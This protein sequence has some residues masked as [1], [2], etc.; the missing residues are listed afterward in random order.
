MKDFLL[1]FIEKAGQK[2]E[3]EL[4]LSTYQK[5]PMMTFAVIHVSYEVL[6]FR[7]EALAESIAMMNR[8]DIYPLV[9][10]RLQPHDYYPSSTS[11]ANAN[12]AFDDATIKRLFTVHSK[13][14]VKEI[15]KRKGRVGVSKEG[16]AYWPDTIAPRLKINTNHILSVVSQHKTVIVNPLTVKN[17]KSIVLD[18]ERLCK[19]LVKTIRSKKYILINE[20]GGILDDTGSV[21]SFLN[22]S[23]PKDWGNVRKDMKRKVR[24]IRE[25]V[26]QIPHCAV[27]VTSAEDLL[28]EI[29]TIKGKGTF[30]KY[31]VLKS[32]QSPEDINQKK[33]RLLIENAFQKKLIDPYFKQK[34]K[35]IIYQK[36]Y[37]GVAI[38]Q[39][40]TGIPYLDKFA[41]G[42]LF[43]G[44]GLGTTLWQKVCRKYPK[45]VWRAHPKNP[46]NRFYLRECDGCIKDDAWHVYWRQLNWQEIRKVVPLV[47]QRK[48]SLFL[49]EDTLASNV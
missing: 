43:E 45:L 39:E 37:E 14:L 17:G 11:M 34:F 28:K 1:R 4:F 38:V 6:K 18:S 27:V 26:A 41:V 47:I 31:H 13:R 30:I 21:L 36:E 40:I 48:P 5:L 15:R 3:V 10:F 7:I 19:A 25:F 8:L 32:V 9:V 12:R 24:D 44:T 23:H 20:E 2:E 46:L 29:F 22:L 49:L 42:K 35:T 33:L 16:V